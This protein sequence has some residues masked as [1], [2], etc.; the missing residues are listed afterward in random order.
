[1]TEKNKDIVEDEEI[2]DDENVSVSKEEYERL[3]KLEEKDHN[4]EERNNLQTLS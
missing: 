4:F 3:K 1:M 2:I